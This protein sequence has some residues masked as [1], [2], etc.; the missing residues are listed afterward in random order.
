MT[1]QTAPVL[2]VTGLTLALPKG[3][4]RPFAVEDVSFE[5]RRGEILCLVGESGSGKTAL[6]H[7]IM[8]SLPAGLKRSAGAIRLGDHSL[9]DLSARDLRR[10]RGDRM[11]MIPQ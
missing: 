8:G 2:T 4:D 9:T 7:A 11:A 10:L 1:V 3:A 6:S 5:V